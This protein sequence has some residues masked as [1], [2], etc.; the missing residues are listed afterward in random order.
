M[1]D[2]ARYRAAVRRKFGRRP[3]YDPQAKYDPQTINA[4][5]YPSR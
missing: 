4:L 1:P 2:K 5:I 3:S